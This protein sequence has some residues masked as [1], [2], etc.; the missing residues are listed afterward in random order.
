MNRAEEP[1]GLEGYLDIEERDAR[2][3][4]RRTLLYLFRYILRQRKF[5]F[6]GI[7]LILVSTSAVLLEPRLL[8][9]AIDEGMIPKSWY[10]LKR[11]ATLFFFVEC[12][13]VS[14]SIGHA[15]LFEALGQR[16]MQDLRM[17]LFTHL[18]EIPVSVYDRNPVGRL[19]TRVTND[20]S[21]LAEMFSAGFV[22]IL[23][24]LLT[25][26]GILVWLLVLNVKLGLLAASVLPFLILASIYFSAKLRIAYR[27]ARSKLSALNAFLA[28]NILG[29]RVVHLFNRQGLHLRRF[30]RVNQWYADAQVSSI[31]V[32][33]FFQPTITISAGMA[34]GL[35]IWFGGRMALSGEIKL[36]ILVAYFSYALSLFQPMRE[37]A[38]KW[39][40][41][42]S[43]MASAE[44]VF[45]I[46]DWKPEFRQG[47]SQRAAGP[48]KDLR[49]HIVFENVWFA[50]DQEHWILRDVSFEIQPGERVGVVGHTGAGKTTIISLLL[51]FYEPQKGKIIL[52][53]KDLREYDKRALRASLGII[54]QDVFLFSGST[55]DNV[56]LWR[57]LSGAAHE[58]IDSLLTSMGLTE[59]LRDRTRS[60]QE[61]GSNLSMGE[62]Q[63]LAFARA[64]VANPAIWILDEA[65]ANVDSQSEVELESALRRISD[66]KTTILIAHRLAT[67]RSA[68]Q[69]LVFHK[70]ALVESGRHVQLMKKGGLYSKLYR[71][72]ENLESHFSQT[73]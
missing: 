17:A 41:F 44:R 56:M 72:Q 47:D 62:R 42:L 71:Y 12:V 32:Y 48:I 53:G 31:R 59:Q 25:V 18:Q 15:Y 14:A 13:R 68:N 61:R 65:T 10:H 6:P 60:L 66:G 26:L 69:I 51:R 22:T 3:V 43:G 33:A 55:W 8:G 4:H 30:L 38:D 27:N 73:V 54:Q 9:F 39:N 23:G 46:L 35:I 29:M 21:A 16:V 64:S 63:I 28:E 52:D 58:S 40:I 37:L 11:I 19:V 50:Y 7:F 5:L 2:P 49:G 36:G 20:V 57:E 34:V 45:S 67:V 70:G 1:S 24:N